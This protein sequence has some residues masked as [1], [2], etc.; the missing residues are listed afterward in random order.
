MI[1]R[2]LLLF[3]VLA[4][5][6]CDKPLFG[7]PV[8]QAT[9]ALWVIRDADT[10]IYLFGTVHVLTPGLRWFSGGL[11]SAFDESDQ[12][13]LEVVM[14]PKEEAAETVKEL[15]FGQDPPLSRLLPP[16]LYA[17]F[18]AAVRPGGGPLKIADRMEPW[19]AALQLSSA[20]VESAGFRSDFGVEM[21]LVKEARLI[22]KPT[23][24][25]ETLREQF[26]YFD[27]LSP[28]AQVALL[29][30]TLDN[31][32]RTKASVEA[33]TEAWSK[34][35]ADTL[36]RLVNDEVKDNPEL[37]AT[38]LTERNRIWSEWI[39][40]R[41]AL[42]GTVFVAVG[43]GHLAGPESVQAMLAQRG[44]KVARVAHRP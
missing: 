42:P 43:A 17:R 23:V 10:T 36:A 22:G 38:L 28:S 33:A 9:P 44:L 34:G 29:A 6:A 35:D 24:G 30:R 7:T 25:L 27:R 3:A 2:L 1:Q 40:K 41:M 26:G 12:I 39:A 15:G 18:A 37:A 4:L 13:V 11:R 16:D 8:K 19:L 5:A 21:T 31:L 20:A 14:P 32:P